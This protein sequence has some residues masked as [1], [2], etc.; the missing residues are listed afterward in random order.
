LSERIA[1]G[2]LR[3]RGGLREL[4]RRSCLSASGLFLRLTD[5]PMRKSFAAS[6]CARTGK[7]KAR[8]QKFQVNFSFENFYHKQ[9]LR[10]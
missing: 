8:G 7:K 4:Y 3:Q 5:M 10:R 9:N 1:V 2:G 6:I